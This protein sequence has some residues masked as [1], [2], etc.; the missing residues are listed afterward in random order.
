M[1]LFEEIKIMQLKNLTI[2]VKNLGYFP[3]LIVKHIQW[4]IRLR[5]IEAR[6]GFGMGFFR[7]HNSHILK[8]YL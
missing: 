3:R 4:K 1:I 7:D 6:G 8:S 5:L 2:E